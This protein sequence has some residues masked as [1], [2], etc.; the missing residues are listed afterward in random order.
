MTQMKKYL[1]AGDGTIVY[2][3]RLIAER[4]PCRYGHER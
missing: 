3:L 4:M 1:D 2:T